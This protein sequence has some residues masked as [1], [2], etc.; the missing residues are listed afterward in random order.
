MKSIIALIVFLTFAASSII[1]QCTYQI[2][3]LDGPLSVNGVMVTVTSDG[4]VDSNSGYCLQTFPYFIGW[5]YDSAYSGTGWY[6]FKFSPPVSSLTLNFS[7]ISEAGGDHKEEIRL[8]VNEVHYAIPSAGTLNGCD[9][10]AVL[11]DEGNIVACPNCPLSG[12]MGTTI[13]G[14]ISSLTVLDTVYYGNPAGTIFSLFICDSLVGAFEHETTTQYQFFPNPLVNQSILKFPASDSNTTFKLFNINGQTVYTDTKI[15][16]GEVILYG[17]G[18][19]P[20]VYSYLLLTE[21][22]IIAKGKLIIQ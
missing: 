12:W 2:T 4:Y 16:N 11:T 1:G 20:G 5:N 8:F 6:N 7:G 18:F 15:K 9:P 10:M 19:L 22:K 3:H 21:T 13:N 14:P 17:E